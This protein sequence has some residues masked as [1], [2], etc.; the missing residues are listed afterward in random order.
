MIQDDFSRVTHKQTGEPMPSE[1]KEERAAPYTGKFADVMKLLETRRTEDGIVKALGWQSEEPGDVLRVDIS[2]AY[3]GDCVVL[4][5]VI[6]A[7]GAL[8]PRPEDKHSHRDES[9]FFSCIANAKS[10]PAGILA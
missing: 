9:P 4:K 7:G 10:I 5:Q 6:R 8:K 1:D 2:K 3:V